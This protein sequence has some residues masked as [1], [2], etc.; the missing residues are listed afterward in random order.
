MYVQLKTLCTCARVC[1]CAYVCVCVCGVWYAWVGV[2]LLSF[3]CVCACAR[4]WHTCVCK[5]WLFALYNTPEFNVNQALFYYIKHF[6][7]NSV[8]HVKHV[9]KPA[10]FLF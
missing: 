5:L 6:T 1:V 7:L 2:C 8:K 3:E 10:F 4:S 9:C